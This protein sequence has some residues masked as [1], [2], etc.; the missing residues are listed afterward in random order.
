MTE[1]KKDVYERQT[2]AH[3]QNIPLLPENLM[4]DIIESVKNSNTLMKP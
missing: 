3:Q 4:A 2:T 1:E